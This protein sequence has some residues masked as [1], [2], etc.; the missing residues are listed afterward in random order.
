[1]PDQS[2]AFGKLL[3]TPDRVP[4]CTVTGQYVLGLESGL[5]P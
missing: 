2:T 1:M 4:R 3:F 5:L